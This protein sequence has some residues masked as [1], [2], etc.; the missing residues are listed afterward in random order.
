MKLKITAIIPSIIIITLLITLYG[1]SLWQLLSQ[2]GDGDML[3]IVAE[4]YVQHILRFSM[5][6]AVLSALLSVFFG[7]LVAHALFYQSF[8]GKKWL[9]KLFSLS[10]VLPVL[11]AIF[12]ILSVYGRVGWLAQLFTWLN[13]DIQPNIYGL[14]GILLAH[15]FFNVPLSAKIFLHSLHSIPHQQR[16]LASQLGIINWNFIRLIEWPYVRQQ[17]L[18]VFTLV[19]MLC[20][21]SFTIILTLGGGPKYTTL[22]VAIFQAITFDSDL[23]RA[24]IFA[25]LQC[26]ICLVLFIL[27]SYLS[28]NTKK[29]AN[30]GTVYI[31]KEPLIIKIFHRIVIVSIV[32]FLGLP[33]VSVIISSFNADAWLSSLRNPTLYKALAFSLVI[34]ICAGSLSIIMSVAILL[35][36]RQFHFIDRTHIAMHIVTIGMI[37]LAVPTLVLAVGLFLLLRQYSVDTPVL[38]CIVVVCNALIAM[39]FALRVLAQ[40]M[41]DNMTYYER[42]CAS[43]GIRGWARFRYIEWCTIRRPVKSAFAL[44]SALSMG[45]FTA[46]ALFGNNDFTSLPRLLYQQLGHYRSDEGAV[47]AMILLIFC[48]L[49]FLVVEQHD[50]NVG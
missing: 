43:L 17:L 39:P 20:F 30:K 42:L 46:I 3:S 49:I 26:L 44:S 24:S 36:S 33:L 7:V 18:S 21:T 29:V 9:L 22:E 10:M 11:V 6:Q 16:Q 40:P 41:Y 28:S 2:K 31:A 48:A 38:F 14:D 5:W 4:P 19:F 27:S 37:I 15:V 34:A 45:D 35:G 47:T 1:N 12:G 23:Q 25:L 32:L 50:D 8:S 13:I